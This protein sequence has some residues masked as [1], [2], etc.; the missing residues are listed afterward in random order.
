LKL[1]KIQE[2]GKKKGEEDAVESGRNLRT[3]R[4]LSEIIFLTMDHGC[5]ITTGKKKPNAFI[6]Y[7][8]KKIF[9]SL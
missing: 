1:E 7:L 8:L 3:V 2:L 5:Q 4:E 9:P 6:I